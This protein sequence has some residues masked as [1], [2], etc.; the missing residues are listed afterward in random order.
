MGLARWYKG[1]AKRAWSSRY[2]EC[3]RDDTCTSLSPTKAQQGRTE[4]PAHASRGFSV[5]LVRGHP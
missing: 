5:T 1:E 2:S 3:S 4:S